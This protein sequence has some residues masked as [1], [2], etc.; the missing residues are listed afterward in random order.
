MDNDDKCKTPISDSEKS[1]YV[2]FFSAR[3][4]VSGIFLFAAI[5]LRRCYDSLLFSR[6]IHTTS[7]I[8]FLSGVSPRG[9]ASGLESRAG[10]ITSDNARYRVERR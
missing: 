5:F 8:C 10:G 7:Q 4:F 3:L 2:A 9:L 1:D 6:K